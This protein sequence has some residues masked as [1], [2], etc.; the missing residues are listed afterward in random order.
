MNI[1]NKYLTF[2]EG[3]IQTTAMQVALEANTD[4]DTD[5]AVDMATIMD[6][7]GENKI[8]SSI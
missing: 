2:L 1:E 6:L 7:D 8:I 5:T 4:M 3:S